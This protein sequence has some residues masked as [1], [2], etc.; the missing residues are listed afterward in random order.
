M[1]VSVYFGWLRGG[2]VE[3]IAKGL[4][5]VFLV[6]AGGEGGGA[7]PTLF[8]CTLSGGVAGAA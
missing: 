3:A 8:D 2:T 7:N 6:V 1:S 5:V 4:T